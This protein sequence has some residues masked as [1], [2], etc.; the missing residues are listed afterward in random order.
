MFNNCL[1]DKFVWLTLLMLALSV[2][3]A[4]APTAT[5]TLAPTIVPAT[6]TS[7]STPVPTVVATPTRPVVAPLAFVSKITGDTADPLAWPNAFAF[8]KQGNVYVA[9]A[10]NRRILKFDPKGKTLAQWGN[11]GSGDGQFK[12]QHIPGGIAID[13]QGNVYV[14]DDGN[15]RI[16][17]FD[18]NGKF[19]TQWGSKGAGDGQFTTPLYVAVDAQGNILVLDFYN[20]NLQ[21]FDSNG[22]FLSKLSGYGAEDGQFASPAGL[23][24][25][26]QGN[27]YVGDA[28][29]FIQKFDKDG[30]F[31]AKFKAAYCPWIDGLAVDAQGNIYA[32]QHTMDINKF[33]SICKFDSTGKT[34]GIWTNTGTDDGQWGAIADIHVDAQGFIY[35][36][37]RGNNRIQKLQQ[38]QSS[39]IASP[40]AS[41]L[42]LGIYKNANTLHGAETLT[43]MDGGRFIQDVP[44]RGARPEGTWVVAG[45]RISFTET[46]GGVCNETGTYKWTFDG[47]ALTLTVIQ[48]SCYPELEDFISG[49]WVKL[50]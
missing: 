24:V 33:A 4:P 19:I 26:T 9:D 30:K 39:T 42:P 7:T 48:D 17:K 45:D 20:T 43:L 27:I 2:G 25:D 44:E 3:C 6:A 47:R 36:A 32:F 13:D 18:S 22:K 10:A 15:A 23:T 16:E 41:E 29:G 34:L 11:L 40:S 38:P 28:A 12:F 1:R 5:P 31:S 8:D 21:K 35:I 14:T 46:A 37:D 49:P 50:P